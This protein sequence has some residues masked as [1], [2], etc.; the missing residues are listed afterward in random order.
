MKGPMFCED[1]AASD[2]RTRCAAHRP[3]RNIDLIPK[4]EM[5][6]RSG[7]VDLASGSAGTQ[8]TVSRPTTTQGHGLFGGDEIQGC[9]LMTSFRMFARLPDDLLFAPHSHRNPSISYP[10]CR[11]QCLESRGLKSDSGDTRR[12]QLYLGT[13]AHTAQWRTADFR[14]HGME[15]R[16]YHVRD[17]VPRIE[18]I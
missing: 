16:L 12:Y 15:R 10:F 8:S 5:K 3:C 1:S 17:G 9:F 7:L 13:E 18:I 6:S 11:S 2:G 14:G 4:G